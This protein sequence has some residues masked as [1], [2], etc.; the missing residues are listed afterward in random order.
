MLMVRIRVRQSDIEGKEGTQRKQSRRTKAGW[1]AGG[2]WVGR[3]VLTKE[4]RIIKK[5]KSLLICSVRL[6]P[7]G[8][9]TKTP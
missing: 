2:R 4:K 3:I 6:A 8:L 7:Q 5:K 9:R 1:E